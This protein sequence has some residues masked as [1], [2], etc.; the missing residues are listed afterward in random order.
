LNV[1]IWI[2]VIA[3]LVVGIWL[4]AQVCSVARVVR[5]RNAL[6]A[7]RGTIADFDW[8]PNKVPAGFLQ[9]TGLPSVIFKDAVTELKIDEC[10]SDWH[11]A[12]RI[13]E[14][15]TMSARDLGPIRSDL[16]TT[17]TRIQA[18]YGYCADFVK[19]FLGLTHAAGIFA[20]QWSFSF[21]GFGGFGHTVVEIFDRASGK[22]LFLDIYNNIH[23]CNALTSAPM[24]ALEFRDALLHSSPAIRIVPNGAGRLGYPIEEKLL[25]Y[26]RRGLR[27]W[28]LVGGNAVFSYEAHPLVR[29]SSR[30]SGPIGQV[31]A[32]CL[33][34]Q[35]SIQILATPENAQAVD[36]LMALARK[37]RAAMVLFLALMAIFIGQASQYGLASRLR[38]V[39]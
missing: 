6:Y 2:N 13:A 25:A 1:L 37:F 22:W 11:R 27:E 10:S 26:F 31:V 20:R 8:R 21:N 16:E 29:W 32:A 35:P 28:Y 38:W 23:A 30:M 15:L 5:L 4:S 19:V 14:R 3:M 36:E 17:Y 18:G 33:G 39:K 24:G 7:R 12:L 34:R 9:E